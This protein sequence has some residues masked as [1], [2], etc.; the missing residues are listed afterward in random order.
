MGK[1]AERSYD[2]ELI[3]KVKKLFEEV[4]EK[5]EKDNA[6]PPL[7]YQSF[8]EAF[9]EN[10][11]FIGRLFGFLV[12]DTAQRHRKKRFQQTELESEP[13]PQ[14]RRTSSSSIFQVLPPTRNTTDGTHLSPRSTAIPDASGNTS[15]QIPSPVRPHMGR[16]LSRDNAQYLSALLQR[17]AAMTRLNYN[18]GL[19]SRDS[20]PRSSTTQI[21]SGPSLLAAHEAQPFPSFSV[22]RGSIPIDVEHGREHER[23]ALA[24]RMSLFAHRQTHIPTISELESATATT[25]APATESTSRNLASGAQFQH[26]GPIQEENEGFF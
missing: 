2:E 5:S 10:D 8:V 3:R 13:L 1:W 20:S 15:R 22:R 17:Q 12:K 24:R 4:S 26:S 23:A 25:T 9:D 11:H 21:T 6:V 19:S 18:S 7:S 16:R 14:R